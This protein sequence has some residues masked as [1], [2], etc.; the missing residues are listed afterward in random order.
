MVLKKSSASFNCNFTMASIG[1]LATVTA[2][3]SGLRRR[4]LHS[5]HFFGVMKR[6][7]SSRMSSLSD[8]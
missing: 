6:S 5:G 1:W 8:S 7:I 3:A 2:S 4:P